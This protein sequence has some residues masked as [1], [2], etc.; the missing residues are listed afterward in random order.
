MHPTERL[1]NLL[2]LLREARRPITFA[3]IR[4]LIPAYQQA[5]KQT[6]K[7]QFERDKDTL[8]QIGIPIE[9][10]A[11]DAWET[12]E[13]YLIPPEHYELPEI[14]FTP[15][16]AAALFVAANAPGGET[17]AAQAF[18]KL[19]TGVDS[20][21]LSG[22]QERAAATGVDA[23]GPHLLEVAQAAQ[24]RRRLR[25]RYRTARG[26][27][28]QRQ[29][30]VW[31]LR[32]LKGTWYLIGLDRKRKEPRAF[33]LS[34]IVS[35]VE[36]AGEAEPPPEGFRAE[37]HLPRGPWGLGEPTGTARVAFAPSAAWWALA[38]I[39]GARTLRTRKDGWT[40]AEVP[41]GESFVPWIVSFGPE[42]RVVSPKALREAVVAHL[43]AARAAL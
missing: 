30:D 31:M 27:A 28:G 16:E 33:R 32:L 37:E 2:A 40:E 5:D 41:A 9:V 4:R 34:R 14:S 26:R 15:E 36:D 10:E 3:E 39:P 22:L 35:K 19:A 23:S 13:G 21:I 8:R 29:V 24:R 42:A 43:E 25:F 20:G 6:A 17:E 7:R 18:R 1:L 12:E 38:D 11:T